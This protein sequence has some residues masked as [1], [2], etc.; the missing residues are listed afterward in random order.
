MEII[1]TKYISKIMPTK[2]GKIVYCCFFK[3]NE[4]IGLLAK[5]YVRCRCMAFSPTTQHTKPLKSM[6]FAPKK[7]YF[8]FLL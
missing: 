4:T 1:Y 7:R 5:P 6:Y 8:L 2:N 3:N